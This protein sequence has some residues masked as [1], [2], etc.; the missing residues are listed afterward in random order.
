M[1]KKVGP[2]L[3]GAPTS[4]DRRREEKS[5]LM[6]PPHER[7]KGEAPAKPPGFLK[8]SCAKPGV[9]PADWGGRAERKG[10][11]QPHW[12]LTSL[13]PESMSAATTSRLCHTNPIWL[14]APHSSKRLMWLPQCSFSNQNVL[15]RG[16]AS[17]LRIWSQHRDDAASEHSLRVV[18][19]KACSQPEER[20]REVDMLSFMNTHLATYVGT[21]LPSATH[22]AVRGWRKTSCCAKRNAAR[23]RGRR[24]VTIWHGGR[25]KYHSDPLSLVSPHHKGDKKKTQNHLTQRALQGALIGTLEGLRR[26]E[27]GRQDVPWL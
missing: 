8:P 13:A 4:S 2:T 9:C 22:N 10:P 26:R 27:T 11:Q 6:G 19:R 16:A 15:S 25:L 14:K 17:E 12:S 23:G 3:S 24:P 21:K 18:C 7:D 5:S 20:Q 1:S